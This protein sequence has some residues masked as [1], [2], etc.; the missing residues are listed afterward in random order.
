MHLRP[1]FR[2]GGGTSVI[3]AK[4][5]DYYGK[6]L[7]AKIRHNDRFMQGNLASSEEMKALDCCCGIHGAARHRKGIKHATVTARRRNDKEIIR[8]EQEE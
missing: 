1:M 4:T 7:K 5:K 3:M 2:S 6:K 8:Q